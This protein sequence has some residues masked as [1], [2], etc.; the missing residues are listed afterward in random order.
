M[1]QLALWVLCQVGFALYSIPEKN[2]QV[3][4]ASKAQLVFAQDKNQTSGFL[5]TSE[6]CSSAFAS[7]FTR[8]SIFG[9]Y[10][11]R[12]C[13]NDDPWSVLPVALSM[14]EPQWETGG[15]LS[16]L[17]ATLDLW[18]SSFESAKGSRFTAESPSTRGP[19]KIWNSS[20][21]PAME[22]R[23]RARRWKAV[24]SVSKAAFSQTQ[25]GVK[26]AKI[27]QRK[28]QRQV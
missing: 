19:A 13:H 8:S 26:S 9:T 1:I 3:S 21:R 4:G 2:A 12:N 18:Y 16:H 15:A 5:G 27:R 23:L 24:D 28:A 17:W 14:W 6:D 7:P 22:L 20:S 11:Q 25:I 10:P